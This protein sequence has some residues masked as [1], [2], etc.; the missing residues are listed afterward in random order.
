MSLTVYPSCLSPFQVTYCACRLVRFMC[1][2]GHNHSLSRTQEWPISRLLYIC[3]LGCT[4]RTF[5]NKM[6][7]DFDRSTGKVRTIR[8]N[9][10][11]CRWTSRVWPCLRVL[12]RRD[13][14]LWL[15]SNARGWC[16]MLWSVVWRD[17][18]VIIIRAI[19]HGVQSVF[20]IIQ[21]VKSLDFVL[22]LRNA[23]ACAAIATCFGSLF[24]EYMW[25]E[26]TH[27]WQTGERGAQ[28]WLQHTPDVGINNGVGD[29]CVRYAN[30]G[31]E[32][33]DADD[34]DAK[35]VSVTLYKPSMGQKPGGVITYVKPMQNMP[36]SAILFC[37]GT[38]SFSTM[39][40]GRHRVIKSVM[41]LK[42]PVIMYESTWFPQEPPGIVWS[43]LNANGLQR[44]NAHR[45][46]LNAHRTTK[47]IRPLAIFRND[48][49]LK[50]LT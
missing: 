20:I 46:T 11:R 1:L 37:F 42:T 44:R 32:T 34:A 2:L 26:R 18:L 6:N 10:S 25:E 43:Q 39:G 3:T 13:I 40:I 19:I 23:E 24:G 5:F 15:H 30:E 28:G 21:F 29:I 47:T 22:W 14:P 4:I 12:V 45:I 36:R 49:T 33:D 35:D 38:W 9:K 16:E 27:Q 48:R 50:I 17:S 7:G 31:D 8:W 41:I